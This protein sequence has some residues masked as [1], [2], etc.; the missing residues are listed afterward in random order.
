MLSKKFSVAA[1]THEKYCPV[2]N[3]LRVRR[4]RKIYRFFCGEDKLRFVANGFPEVVNFISSDATVPEL[5]RGIASIID[6]HEN[7]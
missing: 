6:W 5:W 7:N 4:D 1:K 2:K 3:E